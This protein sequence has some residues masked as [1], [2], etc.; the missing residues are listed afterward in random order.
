MSSRPASALYAA[1]L[2]WIAVL[3]A[4][5]GIGTVVSGMY[6]Q[7][8][9]NGASATTLL[10]VEIGLALLS[11]AVLW[12]G[13]VL[14][15][16][17]GGLEPT[18]LLRHPA[19]PG[20]AVLLMFGA[21]AVAQLMPTVRTAL[22]ADVLGAEGLAYVVQRQQVIAIASRILHGITWAT[23]LAVLFVRMRAEPR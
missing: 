11:F 21:M 12:L 8:L 3:V 17:P 22:L 10:G 18:P 16:R 1:F 7:L 9:Y 4:Q 13:I 23:V 2:W 19:V 14:A 20:V 6:F 15:L 5:A